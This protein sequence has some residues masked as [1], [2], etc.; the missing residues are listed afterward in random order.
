MI[1]DWDKAPEGATH[2]ATDP[3]LHNRWPL[4]QC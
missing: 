4:I 3:H 2:Y 1:I